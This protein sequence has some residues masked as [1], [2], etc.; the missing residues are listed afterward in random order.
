MHEKNLFEIVEIFIKKGI[1]VVVEGKKDLQALCKLGFKRKNIFVLNNGKS[2][3]ENI[4]KIIKFSEKKKEVC[5]LTDFDQEGK[6]LY[7][8]IRCEL[9]K[10][11]IKVNNE[12][13]NRLLKEK[14]THVEGIKNFFENL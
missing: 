8:M 14:V 11:G 4:E 6:R 7:R 5:I 12:L 3:K 1:L 9:I 13:R 2:L 10:I